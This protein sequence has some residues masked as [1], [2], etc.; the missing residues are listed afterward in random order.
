MQDASTDLTEAPATVQ[1]P[2]SGLPA[3]C[4]QLIRLQPAVAH[5]AALP[6][7]GGL[8]IDLIVTLRLC[9]C[10]RLLQ[11]HLLPTFLLADLIGI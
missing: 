5:I 9:L 8:F 10:L 7:A 6:F 11:Q 1:W 4:M 3:P 2:D